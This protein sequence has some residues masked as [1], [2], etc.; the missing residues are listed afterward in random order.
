M[1]PISLSPGQSFCVPGRHPK[2]KKVYPPQDRGARLAVLDP[3][4]A[5]RRLSRGG[6]GH[7]HQGTSTTTVYTLTPTD[8]DLG[9]PAA[10]SG[11][12]SQSRKSSLTYI[13]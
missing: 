4:P 12:G 9:G 6:N 5:S 10:I 2:E 8:Q 11:N 1:R 7:Q 3:W 13:R